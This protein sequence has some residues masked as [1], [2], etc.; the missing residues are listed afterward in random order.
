MSKANP[1]EKQKLFKARRK[2]DKLRGKMDAAMGL[3]YPEWDES[4][5]YKRGFYKINKKYE[6]VAYDSDT[7]AADDYLDYLHSQW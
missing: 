5:S 3:E 7:T 4:Q 1:T 6:K 2:H